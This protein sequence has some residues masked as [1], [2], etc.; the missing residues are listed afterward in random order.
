MSTP[1]YFGQ[2]NEIQNGQLKQASEPQNN[3]PPPYEYILN[4]QTYSN[5][6]DNSKF[7]VPFIESVSTSQNQSSVVE[8]HILTPDQL[9]YQPHP[10][11]A[12]IETDALQNISSCDQMLEYNV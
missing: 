10:S 11:P 4:Q 2:V 9:A 7:T 12:H 8:T 3:Q 5:Q 1:F 6:F